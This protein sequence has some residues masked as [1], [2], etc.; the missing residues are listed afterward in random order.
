[1]RRRAGESL[2]GLTYCG[3]CDRPT[4][5]ASRPFG[6]TGNAIR[7]SVGNFPR[8]GPR[9][10]RFP[11]RDLRIGD[12]PMLCVVPVSL[13][14][15]TLR[16]TRGIIVP[17]FVGVVQSYERVSLN[18]VR[19]APVPGGRHSENVRVCGVSC[20]GTGLLAHRFALRRMPFSTF[21]CLL[22][23]LDCLHARHR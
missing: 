23:L 15:L 11:A 2:A 16:R 7:N 22:L 19:D 12:F 14:R 13:Y 4:I 17:C 5:A 18:D 3:A 6:R 1:M 10:M 9:K 20:L 8:M 21:I